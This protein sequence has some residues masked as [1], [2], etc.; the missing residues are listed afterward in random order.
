[1]SGARVLMLVSPMDFDADMCAFAGLMTVRPARG[2]RG[3]FTGNPRDRHENEP[4]PGD[5]RRFEKPG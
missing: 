5:A 1:M 3:G 2:E 4:A